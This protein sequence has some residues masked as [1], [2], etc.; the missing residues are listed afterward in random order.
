MGERLSN[1]YAL[2][3]GLVHQQAIK[4]KNWVWSTLRSRRLAASGN[5]SG[6]AAQPIEIS[7]QVGAE[8]DLA[9]GKPLSLR[10]IVLCCW[11]WLS[12]SLTWR[13]AMGIQPLAQGQL[14]GAISLHASRSGL[15]APEGRQRSRRRR[16][17]SPRSPMRNWP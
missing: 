8:H 5:G 9:P 10:V 4:L 16:P 2:P 11:F 15:G 3:V 6:F 13:T 17:R 14:G 12:R 1:N 7:L